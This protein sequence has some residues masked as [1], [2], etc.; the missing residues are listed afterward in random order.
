M[1]RVFVNGENFGLMSEGAAAKIREA[2]RRIDPASEV[3]LEPVAPSP[4][5]LEQEEPALA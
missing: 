1:V 5:A 2:A 3:T 4:A